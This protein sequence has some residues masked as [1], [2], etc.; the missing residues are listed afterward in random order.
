MSVSVSVS[1]VDCYPLCHPVHA[2]SIRHE[3][4]EMNVFHEREFKCV[5]NVSLLHE[6]NI[7]WDSLR[8]LLLN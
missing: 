6:M 4:P 8:K 3:Y 7:L 5:L 2:F 1:R